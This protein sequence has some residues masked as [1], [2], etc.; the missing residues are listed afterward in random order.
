MLPFRYFQNDLV[1]GAKPGGLLP[2]LEFS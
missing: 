2:V 1:S